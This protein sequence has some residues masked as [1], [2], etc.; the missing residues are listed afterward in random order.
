MVYF[1]RDCPAHMEFKKT[2]KE[3]VREKP[4]MAVVKEEVAKETALELI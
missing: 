4:L 2:V 3:F 1:D